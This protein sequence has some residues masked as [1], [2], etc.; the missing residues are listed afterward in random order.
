MPDP[1]KGRPVGNGAAVSSSRAG[2]KL[3]VSVA[4]AT[5]TRAETQRHVADHD[6]LD[7]MQRF[8]VRVLTDAIT[9]ALP[10]YWR[11]GSAERLRDRVMVRGGTAITYAT[12]VGGWVGGWSS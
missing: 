9:E 7:Y 10:T 1:R 5:D 3:G 6:G 12:E 4:P 11:R 2:D 8:R